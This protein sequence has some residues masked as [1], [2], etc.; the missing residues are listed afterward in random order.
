MNIQN[1]RYL[2]VLGAESGEL[3]IKVVVTGTAGRGKEGQ[4]LQK[5]TGQRR[6]K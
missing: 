5:R 6:K 1:L 4:K 3:K 2:W